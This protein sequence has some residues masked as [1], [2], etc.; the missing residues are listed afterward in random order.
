[1]VIS[2]VHQS[3]LSGIISGQD[4]R[5]DLR[6]LKALTDVLPLNSKKGLQAFL[7][8]INYLSKFAPLT[9]AVCE[10]L[11]LIISEE[12]MDVEWWV[13]KTLQQ[14]KSHYKRRHMHEVL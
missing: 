8:I 1:M 14:N 4:M 3:I 12:R 13:P 6:K 7:D 5:P 10:A 9:A 11:R 2:G